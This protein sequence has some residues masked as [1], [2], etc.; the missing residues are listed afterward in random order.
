M[1]ILRDA[2]FGLTR[3]DQFRASLGIAP[4]I[5]TGRLKALSEEGLLEKRL[6]SERPPR[7]EYVLTAKGRDFLPVLFVIAGWARAHVGD[8]PL[9]RVVDAETGAPVD[10]MVVDRATGAPIGTR[11][12]RL[13]RPDTGTASG[14]A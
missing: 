7:E 2:G 5:L 12:L 4:N 11:P 9:S 1:L 8:G 13:E 3:F 14:Q 10:P 6:Y